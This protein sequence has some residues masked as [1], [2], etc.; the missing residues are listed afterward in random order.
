[1]ISSK[2]KGH[3]K[4]KK[5][6][7]LIIIVIIVALFIKFCVPSG[8][9]MTTDVKDYNKSKEHPIYSSLFL[10]E[11]DP[12]LDV[13]SFYHY[14]YYYEVEDIYLEIKFQEIDK[15]EEYIKTLKDQ[16]KQA[17]DPEVKQPPY[18]WLIEETN[19]YDSKYIDFICLYLKGYTSNNETRSG[20]SIEI[21]EKNTVI[22]GA[23]S[24]ITYSYEDLTVIQTDMHGFFRSTVHKYIPQYFIRFNIPLTT[25][26]ERMWRW[27]E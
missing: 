13:V 19:P 20:Y 9:Y 2:R 11:L 16:C 27:T 4:V 5:I 6:S 8:V 3:D 22:T 18:G 12:S 26:Y 25:N 1:M 23:F 17:I 24:S 14:N 15:M 10:P 7:I 21:N